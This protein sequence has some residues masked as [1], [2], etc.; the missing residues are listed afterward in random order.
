MAPQYANFE[1]LSK[2]NY[3]TWKIEVEALFNKN[4]HREYILGRNVKPNVIT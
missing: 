3:E 1:K 2:D 4:D